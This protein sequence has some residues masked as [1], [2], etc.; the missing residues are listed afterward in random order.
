V[1]P[2]TKALIF[3]A[4]VL[5]LAIFAR[6]V[7]DTPREDPLIGLAYRTIQLYARLFHRLHVEGREHIPTA[8]YP[9]SL[10]VVCNHTAGVDPLLVQAACP[11]EIRWMMGTDMMVE[12]YEWFWRWAGIIS[13]DRTGRD[14]SGTKEAIR[15]VRSGGVLG[16]FPEGAI[17]RPPRHILPFHPGVGLIIARTGAS[18]LPVIVEGTP[19]PAAGGAWT[20]LYRRG[21]AKVTFGPVME[22]GSMQP[23]PERGPGPPAAADEGALRLGPEETA[24]RLQDWYLKATGWPTAP[25]PM[26]PAFRG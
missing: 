17:E 3:I 2:L 18:V 19:P 10:I 4:A 21:H 9:G 6:W 14:S 26:G 1:P 13:V 12:R 20:S 22:V 11:F 8:R 25:T 15:H 7:L 23:E 24:Q 16:V 5:A